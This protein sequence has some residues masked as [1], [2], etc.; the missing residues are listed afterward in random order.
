[1]FRSLSV[2]EK[3]DLYLSRP[4]SL[5]LLHSV[6]ASKIARIIEC[7][8]CVS[9]FF[10]IGSLPVHAQT[11]L[12]NAAHELTTKLNS[13]PDVTKIIGQHLLITEF[14]NL[15]GNGNA[16]PKL[17]QS[18][19]TTEFIDAK[20]FKVV[21]RD[22]LD[23]AL[24]ELKFGM[25]DLVDADNRR[26][27]GKLVGA[28]YI[29][30]GDMAQVDN[31]STYITARLISIETSDAI[32]AK[33]VT[34]N[35]NGGPLPSDTDTT[36]PDPGTPIA[37]QISPPQNTNPITTSDSPVP[38]K[39][40]LSTKVSSNSAGTWEGTRP[41]LGLLGGSDFK[42]AWRENLGSD[43]VCSFACGDLKG[44]GINHLFMMKNGGIGV[45]E[46]GVFRWENGKFKKL[47]SDQ[48][49][50]KTYPVA[51]GT[52]LILVPFSK[53]PA[54]IFDVMAQTIWHWNGTTFAENDNKR[55]DQTQITDV[56]PGSDPKVVAMNNYL[57]DSKGLTQLVGLAKVNKE[58]GGFASVD[59]WNINFPGIGLYPSEGYWATA[60]DYI[61]NGKTEFAL[62][63][64]TPAGGASSPIQIYSQDGR[65]IGATENNYG[66][67]V[68]SWRPAHAT[69]SFIV[70]RRNLFTDDKHNAGGYLFF[71]RWSGETFEE[72][73]KSIQLDQSLLGFQVC[74]PKNEGEQGLV[75]LSNDGKN[76]Y[77]TKIV[78]R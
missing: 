2:P 18:M 77:L 59:P 3:S 56:L 67:R 72:F 17:L 63:A 19:L 53:S 68:T 48:R 60:G 34:V 43:G 35:L 66:S 73:W 21:E 57:D 69:R 11:I 14:K 33:S 36:Q 54:L 49:G 28:S 62:A 7:F 5:P 20:R 12:Q 76:S 10:L 40:D 30:L 78:A 22:Q 51:P 50:G 38:A 15:S 52:D 42:I 24:E 61:G 16:A 47:W 75:V 27:V 70:A 45:G 41:S 32:A 58:S 8:F 1:M 25:S 6:V 29:L 13:D 44:N 55:F 37:N 26:K 23:K 31:N 4:F 39:I 71:L 74:D 46:V 64:F 9:L 65:R